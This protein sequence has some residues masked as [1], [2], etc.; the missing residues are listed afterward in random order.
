MYDKRI[1]QD[2]DDDSS[3]MR[4]IVLFEKKNSC[5]CRKTFD[6][7]CIYIYICSRKK[8]TVSTFRKICQKRW[9]RFLFIHLRFS[10]VSKRIK[11]TEENGCW[12]ERR[13]TN[14]LCLYEKKEKDVMSNEF[15]MS[16]RLLIIIWLII[17]EFGYCYR[18]HCT[19]SFDTLMNIKKNP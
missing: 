11:K 2:K 3:D 7:C 14:R 9:A 8:S 13:R 17:F 5:I 10:I 18:R 6:S 15:L 4:T 12:N 16:R 19:H 1:S